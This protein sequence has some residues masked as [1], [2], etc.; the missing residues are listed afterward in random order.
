[1]LD[2]VLPTINGLVQVFQD[3]V[4]PILER[5][6]N[7]AITNLPK[8]FEFFKV[9]FEGIGKVVMWVWNNV[10]K[11]V[12]GWIADLLGLDMS[13]IGESFAK[14][15][16]STQELSFTQITDAAGMTKPAAEHLGYELGSGLGGA[17]G[18]AAG[19]AMAK[20]DPWAKF[21]GKLVDDAA[22][23]Q[24]KIQLIGMGFSDGL[25]NQILSGNDWQVV[26]N[27]IT[28]GSRQTIR[29]VERLYY[30][31][32]AGIN[33]LRDVAKAA[34]EALEDATSA[35]ED[36]NRATEAF[37][38]STTQ[39]LSKANPFAALLDK[40]G[41]FE[42]SVASTFTDFYTKISEGLKS[43]L[44]DDAVAEELSLLTAEYEEQ[45]SK[46]AKRVDAINKELEGLYQ[47]RAAAAAFQQGMAIIIASTQPLPRVEQEV[48]RFAQQVIS[49][50]DAVNS[51][52]D[53]GL[54]IGLL[55]DNIATELR[56]TASRTRA[57]LLTIANQRDQLAKT[58]DELVE[59]LNASRD[60]R[61]A[62]KDAIMGVA[63]I[64]TIG[65]SARSMIRNLSKTLERTTRF[66][67]QLSTLQQMGLNREAYNQI[68]NSGLDAGTATARALLRGGPE[69]VKEINN[70]FSMLESEADSLASDAEK[71]MFD[72]G[73]GAIQGFI[74]G[75]IAKD[76]ELRKTAE[77]EATAFNET[78]QRTID[79][80]EANL[81]NTIAELEAEKDRLVETATNLATAFAT[82]FTEIINAAFA[83]AQ[84]QLAALQASAAAA[85]AASNAAVAQAESRAAAA[86]SSSATAARGTT[87]AGSSGAGAGPVPAVIPAV[88]SQR[89]EDLRFANLAPQVNVT[90][91]AGLGTNGAAVGQS[92][93]RVLTQYT[94]TS[95]P[96]AV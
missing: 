25:I 93:A 67:D 47:I 78:F 7:W 14:G 10:L 54:K 57:T 72:G 17:M 68:V 9:V 32:E 36:Y 30:A 69:A 19:N 70:L 38:N 24:A 34:Q 91:N 80:A 5:F 29:E 81:N 58:Y 60:F 2:Y 44:F 76:E 6:V 73:E 95:G 49:S 22:K 71:Y 40:R 56:A 64:T 8:V 20:A 96:V 84:A 66:R 82:K 35:L 65:K 94:R 75:V 48:G 50:F 27:K 87:A 85:V 39:M 15:F 55:S 23:Y 74:D 89:A 4:L 45:L 88:G 16:N 52:I 41:E 26:F 37:L 46:I 90:V 61:Q 42:R 12:F 63:N 77:M 1:L 92:V 3:H 59:K 62:T 31:T 83:V 86:T 33:E 53:D 51:K 21:I 11:P 13:G 79:A 28:S 18:E 43:G